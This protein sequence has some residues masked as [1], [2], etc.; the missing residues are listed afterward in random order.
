[1]TS[2]ATRDIFKVKKEKNLIE[3]TT[4]LRFLCSPSIPYFFKLNKL[5]YETEESFWHLAGTG[6]GLLLKSELKGRVM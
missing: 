3:F 4:L 2:W 6:A 1:M 5:T